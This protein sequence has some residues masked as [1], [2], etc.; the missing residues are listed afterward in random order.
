MGQ[1]S[2]Y[3]LS[4]SC[5]HAKGNFDVGRLRLFQRGSEVESIA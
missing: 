5:R 1:W 3:R 4:D 2:K